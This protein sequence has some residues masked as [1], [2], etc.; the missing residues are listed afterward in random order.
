[1]KKLASLL[2]IN[3]LVPTYEYVKTFFKI[4]IAFVCF[5]IANSRFYYVAVN[6]TTKG[7]GLPP[8]LAKLFKKN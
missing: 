8:L 5:F 4:P 1:M 2:T 6:G 3:G 7:K